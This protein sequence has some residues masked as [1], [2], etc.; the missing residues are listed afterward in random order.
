M[1]GHFLNTRIMNEKYMITNI[2]DRTTV[3][4]TAQAGTYAKA[5]NDIRES[6]LWFSGFEI[7]EAHYAPLPFSDQPCK[8]H[9][10][11]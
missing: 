11:N 4:H 10:Q 6:R 5:C 2:N 3:T 7:P 1:F 8:P 9:S